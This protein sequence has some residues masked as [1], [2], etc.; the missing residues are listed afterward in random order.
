MVQTSLVKSS[1][2]T[3]SSVPFLQSPARLVAVVCAAQVLVRT[4]NAISF[5]TKNATR[6]LN[7]IA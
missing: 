6:E 7:Q 4:K 1:I 2:M 5:V 3:I